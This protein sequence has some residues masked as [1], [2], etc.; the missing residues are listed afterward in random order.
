MIVPNNH[1][2]ICVWHVYCVGGT[3]NWHEAWHKNNFL[4]KLE[5][6]Y[7]GFQVNPQFINN[8]GI[9]DICWCMF[10]IIFRNNCQYF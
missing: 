10:G 4:Y 3:E 8:N 5:G 7:H 2:W 6:S 1:G 9:L